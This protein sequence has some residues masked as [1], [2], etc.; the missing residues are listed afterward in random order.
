MLGGSFTSRLNQNLRED[1]GYTYGAG[2][3]F[4]MDP[5]VG[6]F[7]AAAQVRADVTGASVEQ[8]LA[9]F[10][11]IATGDISAAEVSKAAATIRLEQVNSLESIQ[12]LVAEA[13]ALK[14]VHRPFTALTQDEKALS[15]IS[16]NQLNAL[17]KTAIDYKHGVLVLVGDKTTVLPQ[18][19]GL[20]LPDPVEVKA[21]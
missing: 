3:S 14:T 20:G 7:I 15:A 11:R 9:E 19:K 18:L 10:D 12:G 2:S 16:P 5:N 1:E 4:A 6:Y 8:F 13:M 21:D 17:A